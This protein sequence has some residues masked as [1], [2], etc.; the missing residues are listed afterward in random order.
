MIVLW[1]TEASTYSITHSCYCMY[2]SSICLPIALQSNILCLRRLEKQIL[3][4][5]A[6]VM[7]PENAELTHRANIYHHPIWGISARSNATV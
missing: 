6:V 5:L 1:I 3:R 4:Q 2:V 7:V